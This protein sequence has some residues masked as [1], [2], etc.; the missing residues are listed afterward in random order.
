MEERAPE[1]TPGQ[2]IRLEHRSELGPLSRGWEAPSISRYIDIYSLEMLRS[3]AADR[4]RRCVEVAAL[5]CYYAQHVYKRS[6][7]C[8]L[9]KFKS[10]IIVDVLLHKT[11]LWLPLSMDS[12]WYRRR[13]LYLVDTPNKVEFSDKNWAYVTKQK[14]VLAIKTYENRVG[15][16]FLKLPTPATDATHEFWKQKLS[17]QPSFNILSTLADFANR[18]GIQFLWWPDYY[19]PRQVYE[20]LDLNEEIDGHKR[21]LLRW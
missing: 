15:G 10:R 21:H 17:S 20:T 18:G 9:Q 5:L 1:L 8:I 19:V 14:N 6:W 2:R 13:G 11:S 3:D 7:P 4:G 16:R 12:D